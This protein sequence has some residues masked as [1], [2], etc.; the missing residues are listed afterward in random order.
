VTPS[1]HSAQATTTLKLTVLDNGMPAK[2]GAYVLPLGRF[3]WQKPAKEKGAT[4]E[5]EWF[6]G[7]VIAGKLPL[8]GLKGFD[9]KGEFLDAKGATFSANTHSVEQVRKNGLFV[10]AVPAK[11]ALSDCRLFQGFQFRLID[12]KPRK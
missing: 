10:V 9:L 1:I 4:A 5:D 6:L 11:T 2:D 8:G 7:V 3:D 12:L